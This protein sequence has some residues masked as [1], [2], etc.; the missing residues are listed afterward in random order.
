[1][2]GVICCGKMTIS[3]TGIMGTRFNSCFSRVNIGAPEI[4]SKTPNG[5][6]GLFEQTPINFPSADH[7]R[8]HNKVAHLALHG[9]VIHELEHEIFQNHAQ[10]A[11]A[12]FALHSELRDSFESVIR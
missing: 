1:M 8:G 5:L 6:S 10:S 4:R 9:E 7:I 12:D 2:K 3:R 11:R